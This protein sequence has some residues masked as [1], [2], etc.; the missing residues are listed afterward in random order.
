MGYTFTA[1]MKMEGEVEG[2][3]RTARLG[4]AGTQETTADL[5]APTSAK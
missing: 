1:W 2:D 5:M 4:G 3:S